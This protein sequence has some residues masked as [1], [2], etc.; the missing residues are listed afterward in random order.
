MTRPTRPT[1]ERRREEEAA[2]QAGELESGTR[3]G[4]VVA[5]IGPNNK[6]RLDDRANELDMT[7]KRY[8]LHLMQLDGL[9]TDESVPFSRR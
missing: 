5:E 7:T 4:R 2:R 3:R 9:E 1:T 8:V 6:R